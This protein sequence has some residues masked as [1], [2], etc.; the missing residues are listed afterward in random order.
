MEIKLEGR[1]VE[2]GDELKV[3]V[4][5]RLESLNNRFGP[6]THARVTVSRNARKNE[7]RAQVKIVVNI[8]GGTITASKE[9]PT[10]MAAV[11]ET[12]DTLTEML[13]GHVEKTKKNFR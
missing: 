8:A 7:Q 9:L 13:K 6:I 3:R 11:N 1:Q 12:L 5:K 4:R 2:L 10:V